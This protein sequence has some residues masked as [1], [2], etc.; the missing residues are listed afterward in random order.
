MLFD[1]SPD[2]I[3]GMLIADDQANY[4]PEAE[5]SDF[6][7]SHGARAE[8]VLTQMLELPF[9]PFNFMTEAQLERVNETI[10]ENFEYLTKQL[11]YY[12]EQ[13]ENAS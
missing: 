5:S 1:L 9:A 11:S 8:G 6:W 2:L 13:V 3:L 12:F 4:E 10:H 7:N